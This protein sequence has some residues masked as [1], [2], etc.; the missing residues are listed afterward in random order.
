M[1]AEGQDPLANTD[2]PPSQTESR[3]RTRGPG[4][5]ATPLYKPSP[6]THKEKKIQT[7]KKTGAK[8][9]GNQKQ[10]SPK[11]CPAVT[12]RQFLA[13]CKPWVWSRDFYPGPTFKGFPTLDSGERLKHRLSQSP[14]APSVV[15]REGFTEEVIQG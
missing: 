15:V 7:P 9:T 12:D 10:W 3:Y 6:R 11:F 14:P 2:P 4:F 1:S 13:L 8:L 5:S